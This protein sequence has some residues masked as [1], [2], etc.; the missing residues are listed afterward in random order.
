[1]IFV[2][3]ILMDFGW[4]FDFGLADVMGMPSSAAGAPK[5]QLVRRL[6][7]LALLALNVAEKH[8]K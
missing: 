6:Q 5:A 7:D 2:I 1:M 8:N 4:D 3:L